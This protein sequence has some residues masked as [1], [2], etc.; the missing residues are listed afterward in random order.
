MNHIH[1]STMF[2]RGT[3]YVEK[4][5]DFLVRM[6]LNEET[7]VDKDR[8]KRYNLTDLKGGDK[9]KVTL[10]SVAS[11]SFG[12]ILA[13]ANPVNVVTT[14]GLIASGI[15]GFVLIGAAMGGAVYAGLKWNTYSTARDY[16]SDDRLKRLQNKIKVINNEI[17]NLEAKDLEVAEKVKTFFESTVRQYQRHLNSLQVKV[18]Y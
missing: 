12:G 4:L 1:S 10:L 3:G 16:V 7:E 13:M 2:A 17:S 8:V 11:G 6:D 14:T 5:P 18:N 15:G 9:K